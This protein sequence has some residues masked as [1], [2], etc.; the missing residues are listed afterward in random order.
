MARV[1][2]YSGSFTVE[3]AKRNFNYAYGKTYIEAQLIL[4]NQRDAFMSEMDKIRS[5]IGLPGPISV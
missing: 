1:M 4:T 2:R 3:C 5:R